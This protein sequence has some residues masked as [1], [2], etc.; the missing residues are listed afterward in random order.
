MFDPVEM[1]SILDFL[2]GF[3]DTRWPLNPPQTMD[4]SPEEKSVWIQLISLIVVLGGYLVI[5][6]Q[7]L[8]RGIMALPAYAPVFGVAVVLLIIA[9]AAGHIWAA[10]T[11]GSPE[12]D[13][14]D[15]VIG[16]RAE[17]HSSW[18]LGVGVLAAITCL[19]LS[20]EAVWVAHLLFLSLFLAQVTGHALQLFYYRRGL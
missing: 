8:A 13:E 17:N 5:A 15:R 10:I 20:V 1:S 9:L 7:M 14:R 11:S 18:I 3:L 19:V 4:A 16:W 6:G 2:N 12:R